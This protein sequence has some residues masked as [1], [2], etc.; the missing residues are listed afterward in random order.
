MD[1]EYRSFLIRHWLL[2]PGERRVEVEH[3]QSGDRMRLDSMTAAFDWIAARCD[4]RL[5]GSA[6]RSAL[7]SPREERGP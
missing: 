3:V 4:S 1:K 2:S 7:P 6:D 5:A